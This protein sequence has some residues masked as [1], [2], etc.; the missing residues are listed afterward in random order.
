MTLALLH[1]GLS[2]KRLGRARK[3]QAL[4][5]VFIRT[6]GTIS[7]GPACC[8]QNL[9]CLFSFLSSRSSLSMPRCAERNPSPWTEIGLLQLHRI[10]VPGP[11]PR[12]V[13]REI[14]PQF[15]QLMSIFRVFTDV[16][17][18]AKSAGPP[19]A[20]AGRRI[21]RWSSYGRRLLRFLRS[22][23][24]VS[25]EAA[26][27]LTAFGV[28]LLASNLAALEATFREVRSFRAMVLSS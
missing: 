22:G 11:R 6:V 19:S 18:S 7:S 3:D 9:S 12:R 4:T 5:V 20:A 23:A 17:A 16:L 21:N 10:V 25:A 13:R 14:F 24:W 28:F 1:P 2:W 26:T 8:G 27:L 15:G